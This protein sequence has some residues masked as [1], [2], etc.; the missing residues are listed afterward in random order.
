MSESS[1]EHLP[2]APHERNRRRN[3]APLVSSST[4]PVASPPPARSFFGG[5]QEAGFQRFCTTSQNF[6]NYDTRVL[7]VGGS[8]QGIVA[9]RSKIIHK[10]QAK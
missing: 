2:T 7:E 9:V 10:N 3:F 8:N 6:Y 1:S 4:N 5:A